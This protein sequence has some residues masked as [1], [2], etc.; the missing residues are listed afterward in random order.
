ME[1]S[2]AKAKD[3]T[4]KVFCFLERRRSKKKTIFSFLPF[5][6]FSFQSPF[7]CLRAATAPGLFLRPIDIAVAG[8]A[9]VGALSAAIGGMSA[10]EAEA[11]AGSEVEVLM[12]IEAD[13]GREDPPRLLLLL[14][15][16][17]ARIPPP[18]Q[19]QQLQLRRRPAAPRPRR[20]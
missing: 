8:E 18:Q 7:Q 16:E 6:F 15:E 1:T 9:A 14:P 2:A 5:V 10:A 3:E 4:S 12:E 11:G 20:P 13:D 19:E 17:L